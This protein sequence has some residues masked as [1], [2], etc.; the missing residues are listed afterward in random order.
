MI[1]TLD[2]TKH[3]KKSLKKKE[4]KIIRQTENIKWK[5]MR[6]YGP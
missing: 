6:L 4:K 3:E 2:I 1:L 5:V